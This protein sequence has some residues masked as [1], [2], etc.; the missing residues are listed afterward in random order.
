MQLKEEDFPVME[1][2][3]KGKKQKGGKQIS[4]AEYHREEFGKLKVET[5]KFDLIFK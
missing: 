3:K 1:Q 4:L 5:S 2:A